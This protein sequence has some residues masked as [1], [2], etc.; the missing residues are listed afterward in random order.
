MSCFQAMMTEKNLLHF[1]EL[2]AASLVRIWVSWRFGN[3]NTSRVFCGQQSVKNPCLSSFSSLQSCCNLCSLDDLTFLVTVLFN[4]SEIC[5]DLVKFFL[6]EM[7]WILFWLNS[8]ALL[9]PHFTLSNSCRNNN[10][11]RSLSYTLCL[12]INVG[13]PKTVF[14]W[15]SW[16]IS[17]ISEVKLCWMR[18]LCRT[19]ISAPHY[20]Q[21]RTAALLLVKSSSFFFFIIDHD[22]RQIPCRMIRNVSSCAGLLVSKVPPAISEK[23]AKSTRFRNLLAQFTDPW[24]VVVKVSDELTLSA[25]GVRLVRGLLLMCVGVSKH[26]NST[27]WILPEIFTPAHLSSN[28]S[29]YLMITWVI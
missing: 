26:S 9:D 23:R 12:V 19:V 22:Q 1:G 17:L 13:I 4:A 11:P 16:E 5:E 15:R 28:C 14:L 25:L 24:G 3:M 10:I 21:V 20:I 29:N 27:N 18:H 6:I 2:S 8:A 7:I